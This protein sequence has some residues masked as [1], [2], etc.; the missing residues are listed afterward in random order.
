LIAVIAQLIPR[1]AYEYLL[2]RAIPPLPL[3]PFDLAKKANN[4]Y[5]DTAS[6]YHPDTAF[7]TFYF[8]EERYLLLKDIS[9][10]SERKRPISQ[11]SR[12]TS[13]RAKGIHHLHIPDKH[14]IQET[15]AIPV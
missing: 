13:I 5:L 11:K 6:S 12:V 1:L 3:C 2:V 4:P 9:A 7:K 14:P 10:S 15:D 8:S